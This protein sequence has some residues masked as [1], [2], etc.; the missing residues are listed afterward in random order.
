MPLGD[1]SLPRIVC[2]GLTGAEDEACTDQAMLEA[3]A[4]YE[5]QRGRVI[6][7]VVSAVSRGMLP[8]HPRRASRAALSA[9]R[10]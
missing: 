4:P 2:H 1:D 3:L 9:H 7:L 6:R 8:R 10:Y 5:G